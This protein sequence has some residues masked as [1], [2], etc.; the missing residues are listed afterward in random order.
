MGWLVLVLLAFGSGYGVWTYQA[1]INNCTDCPEMVE[2]PGGSFQM[3]SNDSDAY[4]NEKPVHS[5]NVKSFSIG[6]YEVT[7]GQWRAVMGSNPSHFANC[8]DN[9][10]VENVSWNDIQSHIQKLNKKTGQR[11]RLPSEAEWEY[12]CLGGQQP[13]YC[14]SNDV[15]SVAWYRDNSA[16]TTHPVGQKAPNGFGLYDMSGNVWEWVEDDY[17]DGYLGAPTDGA[18]RK[19]G[20]ET[21]V[22]RG[23][24]WNSF[25]GSARSAIRY[26]Y[27]PD[28]RSYFI[29]F[30]L[31]STPLNARTASTTV[32]AGVQQGVHGPS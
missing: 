9:C 16:G 5:V 15:G 25:A 30:R 10:P 23:G 11:F 29:G 20:V 19:T 26:G 14:G 17:E 2:V 1:S 31:A 24:S 18:A 8:G 3:G 28:F 32:P 12:A 21:R 6:K 13:I 7:Q 4:N 27:S 22:L